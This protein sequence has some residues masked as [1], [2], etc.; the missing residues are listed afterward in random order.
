MSTHT[1]V[2]S[3][4]SQ[5]VQSSSRPMN[6]DETL[7][8]I[9][10]ATKDCIPGVDAA[11]ISVRCRGGGL[12]TLVPTD[13]LSLAG[14][15]AQHEAGEGPCVDAAGGEQMIFSGYIGADPRYRKYGPRAADLGIISQLALEMYAADHIFGGLNLYSRS[16]EVFDEEARSL[17]ELFAAQGAAALGYAAT[18]RD[19]NEALAS[20]KVIG[21]AMG[22]I[23]ER[24]NLDDN[25]SFGFL[26]RLSQTGN[27][28]LRTVAAEIVATANG[29]V[30][31]N[32][33]AAD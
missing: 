6:R 2:F 12:E 28:K 25:R 17:A 24:Y 22:I 32:T 5:V 15:A 26:A 14:D 13:G 4:L 29:K 18:V 27:V 9:T 31:R 1:D 10:Q 23:T 19:L 3:A 11:S 30:H 16:A 33:N 7:A 20:R 8:I 21:Q